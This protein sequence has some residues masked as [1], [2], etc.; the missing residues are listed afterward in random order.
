MADV[1]GTASDAILDGALEAITWKGSVGSRA[2]STLVGRVTESAVLDS[3]LCAW[4]I[5]SKDSVA[6]L[7]HCTPVIH[8]TGEAISEVA[9]DASLIVCS[10]NYE[11]NLAFSALSRIAVS[12]TLIVG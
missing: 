12:A 11:P 3:A 7:A 6:S 2:C 9:G 1:V 4:N 5:I 10:S 8:Y